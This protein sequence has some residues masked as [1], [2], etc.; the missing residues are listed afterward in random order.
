M[1][2]KMSAL[3]QEGKQK[4]QSHWIDVSAMTSEHSCIETIF[5]VCVDKEKKVKN[6]LNIGEIK[7]LNSPHFI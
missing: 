5:L 7:Q 1:Q 3:L 2:I 4:E 6:L